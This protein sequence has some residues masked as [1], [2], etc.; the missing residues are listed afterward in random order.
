MARLDPAR[1]G[2]GTKGSAV[3]KV[4]ALVAV[5][6]VALIVVP[7]AAASTLS[8]SL[9]RLPGKVRLNSSFTIQS[10]QCVR[11]EWGYYPYAC[12]EAD[13]VFRVWRKHAD[14]WRR[15]YSE[16][17]YVST[18]SFDSLKGSDVTRIYDWEYRGYR[19]YGGVRKSRRHRVKVTLVDNFPGTTNPTQVRKF[20][21]K[22]RARP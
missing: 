16:S 9:T 15:V 17:W 10:P 8:T 19:F 12:T 7:A 4:L 11:D 1:R 18:N 22:Y 20:R 14:G 5:S 3:K 13:L 2:P 6:A 21:A